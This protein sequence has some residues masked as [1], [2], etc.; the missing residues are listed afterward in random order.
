MQVEG[1]TVPSCGVLVLKDTAATVEQRR[2]S[3]GD[4][5]TCEDPGVGRTT[6]AEGSAG[7]SSWQ[8]QKPSKLGLV[9]VAGSS[10]LWIPP[11]SAMNVDISGPNLV[12]SSQQS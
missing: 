1:V 11:L 3:P 12:W 5:C 10:A 6:E 2:R 7:I 9:K 8:S 4:E